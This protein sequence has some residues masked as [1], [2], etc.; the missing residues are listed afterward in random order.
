MKI[1]YLKGESKMSVPNVNSTGSM[2][3]EKNYS[4]VIRGCTNEP[5]EVFVK[6]RLDGVELQLS[7][8]MDKFVQKDN[9]FEDGCKKPG[10]FMGT[11][12]TEDQGEVAVIAE[13]DPEKMTPKSL[14]MTNEDESMT[15][16]VKWNK[17]GDLKT[18]EEKRIL[19]THREELYIYGGG[20]SGNLVY[21]EL[22]IER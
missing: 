6:K 1:N 14:E 3:I 5:K 21:K 9:S 11:H 13:F 22:N 12:T 16:T 17:N 10:R 19:D 20:K 18:V 7:Q 8:K 4:G 2:G 15:T